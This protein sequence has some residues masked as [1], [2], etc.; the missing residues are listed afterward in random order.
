MPLLFFGNIDQGEPVSALHIAGKRGM[1]AGEI[2][3]GSP[4]PLSPCK[5]GGKPVS[6]KPRSL[7]ASAGRKEVARK[8]DP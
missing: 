6:R 2:P 5:L 7:N 1:K 8:A 3:P 4:S